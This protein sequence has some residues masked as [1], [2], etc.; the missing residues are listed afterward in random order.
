MEKP[1]LGNI[2]TKKIHYVPCADGRCKLSDIK[3]ENK[4][5]FA[6]L[7]EGLDYPSPERRILAP[8][9]I[10]IKKYRKRGEDEKG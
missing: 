10:C 4:V 6:T 7:Q 5:F 3:E 1:F 2:G 9:G 8:C